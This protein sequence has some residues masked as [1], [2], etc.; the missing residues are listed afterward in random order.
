MSLE[1]VTFILNVLR[2]VVL[3]R[4]IV[5][6]QCVKFF[7]ITGNKEAEEKEKEG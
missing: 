5:T 7:F 3:S 1:I 4:V 6:L 2:S